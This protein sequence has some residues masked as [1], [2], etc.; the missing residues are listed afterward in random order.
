MKV[1]IDARF[2]GPQVKGLGRYLQKLIE[3]LEELEKN[4][5]NEFYIFLT[6]EGYDNYQP[7]SN[8]FHKVLADFS[9][10][11]WKEQLFFPFFL[12]KYRLDLMHFGHFNV[13]WLYRKKFVVTIHDLILFHYPTFKNSTLSRSYYLV[14][15][16]A[17]RFIINSSVKRAR[18]VI[19]VSDFTKRDILNN[20]KIEKDKVEVVKEGYEIEKKEQSSNPETI[21]KKYGIVKPY[22]LYVGNAY[23]HKNLERL[24]LAF[25]LLKSA[26]PN[27]NLILVGGEDYFYRRLKRFVG[28]R[29][30]E[31][32][33]FTGFVEDAD[34]KTVYKEAGC[35]VFPS[36]YE[37]FGLPPLEALACECPVVSSGKTSMPEVLGEAAEYFDPEKPE[38]IK[39]AIEK[40]LD[41]PKR[42]KEILNK[43]KERI[44]KFNWQETGRKTL[45]VYK[46][47]L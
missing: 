42:R 32:V 18:K 34:L 8:N 45:Q 19:A 16:I 3:N 7:Q 31:G 2:Y 25:D 4:S 5:Q 36:L 14:K 29:K 47:S 30:T 27:L 28:E 41:S 12:N 20:F 13:P 6:K 26:Y 43:G 24:I 40:V 33:C 37:G 10:Y 11:G 44:K 21:L 39:E 38:L 22:L 17:Y 35:L 1:G 46:K 23:P 15:L 9:W